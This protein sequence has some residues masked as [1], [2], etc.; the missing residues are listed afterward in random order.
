MISSLLHSAGH[1]SLRR[2]Y[3]LTDATGVGFRVAVTRQRVAAT[4][5]FNQNVRPKDSSFDVNGRHLG[6]ADADFVLAE[7]RSLVPDDRLVRHFDDGGKKEIPARPTARL[8]CF[9]SHDR[10]IGQSPGWATEF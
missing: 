9:R 8:K 7:L 2:F 3:Q 10:I 6:D 1:T 4:G 5:R